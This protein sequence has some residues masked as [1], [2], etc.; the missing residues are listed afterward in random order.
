MRATQRERFEFIHL[1]MKYATGTPANVTAET[2][3]LVNEGDIQRA[4]FKLLRYGVTLGRLAEEQCNGYQDWKGNWD[5]KRTKRAEEKEAR[6]ERRVRELCA[7]IGV[8]ADFQGDP[9]GHVVKIVTA[10]HREF[11]VPTS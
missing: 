9:R 8:T 5:E 3:K 4:A 10:D 1:L 6:I 11:G 7:E 2:P